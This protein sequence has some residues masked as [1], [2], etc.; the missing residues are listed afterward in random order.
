MTSQIYPVTLDE[1]L[2]PRLGTTGLNYQTVYKV[3]KA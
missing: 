2:M 3:V 1:R